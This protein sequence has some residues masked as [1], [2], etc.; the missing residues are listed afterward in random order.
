[1]SPR[2]LGTHTRRMA[3][4]TIVALAAGAGCGGDGGAAGGGGGFTRPPTPVEVAPVSRAELVDRF[5]AVGSFEAVQSVAVVSEVSGIVRELP[6]EEGEPVKKGA[7]LARLEDTELAAALARSQ[8]LLQQTRGSYER[9]K[10]VVDQNAGSPQDLDDALAALRVAEADVD[11]AKARLEKTRVRA[12]FGGYVGPRLVSPGAFVQPGQPITQLTEL[13]ELEVVF[14]APEAY[15]PRLTAGASITVSTPAY[16]GVEAEGTITIV[17]PILDPGTR[18]VEVIGRVPNPGIRFRPGM[19]ADVVAVLS[20][21]PDALTVPSAAVFVDQG[22]TIVYVVGQDSTVVRTPVVLGTRLS[23]VVE[24]LEGLSAGQS[25]V[26]AGHQKL[27]PGARVMPIPSSD[28][29]AS[30]G[31]RGGGGAGAAPPATAGQPTPSGESP[32]G[33]STASSDPAAEGETSR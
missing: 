11:L 13:D 19:S 6:F 10:N 17:D 23:A 22:Q 26:Q 15:L 27:F 20:R 32:K 2:G 21:K 30:P 5:D 8:A 24:V 3:L 7:L 9:V 28:G 4:L 18:T 31:V 33:E 1:M 25:V 16:P 14:N 29:S 12:S